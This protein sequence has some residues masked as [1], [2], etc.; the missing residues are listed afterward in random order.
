MAPV[1]A[2]KLAQTEDGEK[3]LVD[4]PLLLW[5]NL[6]DEFAESACVDCPDLFD[7]NPGCFAE[8]VYLRAERGRAGTRRGG[9][10]EDHRPW[11]ELVGLDDNS[12]T[13]T[14][15]LMTTAMG[16]TKLVDVTPEHACS[17]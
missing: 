6:T 16:R 3:S 11:Q 7:E 10:D 13:A 5:A 2:V 1:P 4:T 15:L 8:Q 9:R 14:A 12:V 17:P